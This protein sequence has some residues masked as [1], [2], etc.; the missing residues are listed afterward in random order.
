M[1]RERLAT[2]ETLYKQK[3][4]LFHRGCIGEKTLV[5]QTVKNLPAMRETSVRS[6]G[7]KDPLEEGMTPTPV[8]WPGERHGQTSLEDCS[9]WGHKAPD[10]PERLSTA[11][12]KRITKRP[13]VESQFSLTCIILFTTVL[14]RHNPTTIKPT[15]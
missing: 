8:F 12:E 15:P 7:W 5:A 1:L 6:L 9:Q 3:C 14:S 4:P 10:T 11:A 2:Q 13:L